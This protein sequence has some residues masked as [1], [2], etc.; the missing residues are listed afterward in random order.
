MQDPNERSQLGD[1]KSKEWNAAAVNSNGI[2]PLCGVLI[3]AGSDQDTDR[4]ELQ[5]VL[6]QL[7]GGDEDVK[8]LGRE[9][10]KERENYPGHKQ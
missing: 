6:S 2:G 5:R 10:G 3:M 4:A 7:H 1:P 9:E 8:E